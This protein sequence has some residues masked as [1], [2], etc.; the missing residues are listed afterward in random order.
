MDW[1]PLASRLG[2]HIALGYVFCLLVL[3]PAPVGKFFYK[4]TGWTAAITA[5]RLRHSEQLQLV[6]S[7]SSVSTSKRTAPQ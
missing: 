7:V 4:L 1:L 5:F 3:G 2:L 6:N